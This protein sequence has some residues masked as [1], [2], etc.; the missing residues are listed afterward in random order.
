MQASHQNLEQV[1]EKDEDSDYSQNRNQKLNSM[2]QNIKR[3]D[4]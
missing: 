2:S 3:V 1:E 4:S